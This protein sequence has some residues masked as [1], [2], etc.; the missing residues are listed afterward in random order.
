LYRKRLGGGMRQ[1]GI[2]AA[3]GLIALEDSPQNLPADHANARYLAESL[4][5]LPGIAI[6]PATVV[7]NIVIFDISALGIGTSEF[8]A[9]LK[10]RGVLANGINGT[11]MRMVTHSDV[12]ADDC[13]TAMNVVRELMDQCAT[14]QACTFSSFTKS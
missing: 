5:E 4:A 11:H 13:E 12:S 10:S 14:P 1:A 8:S 3:A 6:D 9:R 2:L 7:T